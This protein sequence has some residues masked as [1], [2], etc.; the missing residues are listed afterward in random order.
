MD[1][2]EREYAGAVAGM[3]EARGWHDT[4]NTPPTVGDLMHGTFPCGEYWTGKVEYILAGR[5]H[6]N[7]GRCWVTVSEKY[8]AN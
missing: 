6:I 5:L 2:H 7:T 8:Q 4:Q 1:A 3:N